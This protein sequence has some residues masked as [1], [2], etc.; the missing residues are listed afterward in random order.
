MTHHRNRIRLLT[1]PL[2]AAGLVVASALTAWAHVEVEAHPAT[3]GATDVT[4]TLHVPNGE[5]APAVTTE[6]TFVL[7]ADHPLVGVTAKPQNGFQPITTT[8]H[9][10]VS[11]PGTHGPVSD[12][13][14][15]VTFSGGK[16]TGKDEKPFVLHVDKLPA[17]VRTLTFKALQRYNN[18]TTVSWIEVPANGAAEPEHPAPVL[19]L[20]DLPRPHPRPLRSRPSRHG[21]HRLTAAG[22]PVAAL[23][24]GAL[25]GS[26]HDCPSVLRLRPGYDWSGRHKVFPS[27]HVNHR[28]MTDSGRRSPMTLRSV[29]LIVAVLVCTALGGWRA[30]SM[31]AAKPAPSALVVNGVTYRVTHAEQ[32]KGLSDSALGGMS[33]GI[34]SLVRDDKALVTLRMVVTAG[35]S[36]AS[37]DARLLR[38]FVKG[39][40]VGT[41][42]VGGLL[43]PGRL[44]AHASIEGF[45][46]F[47]VPR[48]G[49]EVALGALG[50]SRE[51][52]LLQVD[53]APA[54]AGQHHHPAARAVTPT[55]GGATKPRHP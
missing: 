42:P 46:S 14:S 50:D 49:A 7:P 9:L 36:T 11:V 31:A 51:V 53:E 48:N 13:V 26:S 39:S 34:M 43:A 17:G 30:V 37:Y 29:A 1:V 55:P 33:H 27:E 41:K 21:R 6:V 10:A 25:A 44:E 3:V 15:Q 22:L 4:L 23:G 18:G 28:G 19:T 24:L 40:P 12:V 38:A 8:R 35:D 54:G 32:V 5:E 47:V 45:L 2:A 20:T 16:I 52:P